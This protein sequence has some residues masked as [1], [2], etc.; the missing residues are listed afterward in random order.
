[1]LVKNDTKLILLYPRT[2]NNS[3]TVVKCYVIKI[4]SSCNINDVML[5]ALWFN[6]VI[7]G[8]LGNHYRP[9]IRSKAF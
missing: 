8:I 7:V 4:A 9:H 3:V 2:L 6:R 1:M 5:K